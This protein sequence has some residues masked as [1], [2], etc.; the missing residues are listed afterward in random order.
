MEIVHE[1]AVRGRLNA[2]V[3]MFEN[4]SKSEDKSSAAPA[5]R[6]KMLPSSK[7]QPA[8]TRACEPSQADE[9]VGEK[10]HVDTSFSV[11]SLIKTFNSRRGMETS[12]SVAKR[13]PLSGERRR[14]GVPLHLV[15]ETIERHPEVKALL[16][17]VFGRIERLFGRTR[18][19][20]SRCSS[21]RD[22]IDDAG[23]S[24]T[25]TTDIDSCLSAAETHSSSENSGSRIGAIW[26]Q[27][28]FQ[29]LDGCPKTDAIGS[30]VHHV[31]TKKL[32]DYMDVLRARMAAG[33]HDA[34][35]P[36]ADDSGLVFSDAVKLAMSKLSDDGIK[37]AAVA[38]K[39]VDVSVRSC[40]ALIEMTVFSGEAL[41][42]TINVVNRAPC[43]AALDDLSDVDA[44]VLFAADSLCP[45]SP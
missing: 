16:D 33:S 19:F 34:K 18:S 32:R 44:D 35:A 39:S 45:A 13:C 15:P 7:L 5:A 42:P 31:C 2:L 1:P 30:G 43:A 14:S 27:D 4:Q 36:A 8:L 23:S 21:E 17:D 25:D 11:D 20:D 12:L 6:Q 29:Y 28:S 22:L 38:D 10:R 37:D 24:V 3:Q 9:T 26:H 41:K 40:K